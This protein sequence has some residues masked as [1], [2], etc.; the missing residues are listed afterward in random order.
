MR[1]P[2]ALVDGP[3]VQRREVRLVTP[4]EARQLLEAFRGDR[5]EALYTVA[6]AVGLR[7]GEA[8][9]LR[10][11]DVDL[12]SGTLTVRVALERAD[13]R[14]RLA[15]PKTKRSRRTIALPDVAIRALKAHR[16][17]QSQERLLAGAEWRD[18]WGLVFTNPS[19]APLH[20]TNVTRGFR[21][22][23]DGASLPSQRFHD[24]RHACAS[25]LLVQGIHARV[26]METLG[27]SRIGLTMDT[28]GHVIPEL[29]REAADKMDVLLASG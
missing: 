14:F 18:A 21:Q 13:G 10:W 26:I 11:Q 3:R 1:N 9:G 28:Y 22:V 15:E 6:L 12:E 24:L 20:G 29:Q 23:L 5:L 7:Q 2:A 17:R 8:L 27:H 16:T 19:G 25:L 4:G